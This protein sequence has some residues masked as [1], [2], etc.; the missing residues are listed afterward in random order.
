MRPILTIA[1]PTYNRLR[2]LQRAL[3]SILEQYDNR[4]EILVSD[5]DSDDGTYEY[6]TSLNVDNVRILYVKNDTNVGSMKNFDNCYR[7]ASGVYTLLLGSDDLLVENCLSGLCDYLENNSDVTAFFI[8]HLFFSGEYLNKNNPEYK[9]YLGRGQNQITGD[10][11]LFVK[12][13]GKQ[14][15]FM[16]C[17]ALNT[18][19]VNNVENHEAFY[20]THFLH[21]CLLLAIA[22]S[23]DSTF[24]IIRDVCVA[25]DQ[26]LGHSEVD[27]DFS[28]SFYIFG[29]CFKKALVDIGTAHNFKK[30]TMRKVFFKTSSRCAILAIFRLKLSKAKGWKKAFVSGCFRELSSFFLSWVYIFPLLFMPRFAISI[31]YRTASPKSYR[32]FLS[33]YGNQ[34]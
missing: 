6:M 25:Q 30:R 28:R 1:I 2:F 13:A 7:R 5:N 9:S 27:N 17:L 16:S 31:M 26:S 33:K 4:V 22:G 32:L 10:K 12:T 8:N 24:G 15:S 34:Q 3:H 18:D 19:G 11:D 29:K 14:L 21:T 23:N 20:D